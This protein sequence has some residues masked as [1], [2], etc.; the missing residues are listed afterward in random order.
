MDHEHKQKCEKELK[1]N[2]QKLKEIH[3]AGHWRG[4][5]VAHISMLN[6]ELNAII[7]YCRTKKTIRSA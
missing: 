4:Y 7:K 3:D 6:E 1:N 2:L 5:D